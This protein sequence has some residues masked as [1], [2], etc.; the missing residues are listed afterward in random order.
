DGPAGAVDIRRCAGAEPVDQVPV[1]PGQMSS[2]LYTSGSTGVPKGVVLSHAARLTISAS[3]PVD[4]SGPGARCGVVSTGSSGGTEGVLCIPLVMGGTLVPYDV[5]ERGLGELPAWLRARR[6][7]SLRTVPTV[8]RQLAGALEPGERFDDL[9]SVALFGEQ[10]HWAEVPRLRRA[11]GVGAVIH[12]TYGSSEAGIVTSYAVGPD[13]RHGRGPV[14]VGRAVPGRSVVVDDDGEL[15]AIGDPARVPGS[16]WRRPELTV[17]RFGVDADGRRTC[18]TG[19]RGRLDGDGNLHLDGR[20]D[21]VVKIGGVR[22]DRAEVESVLADLAGVTGAAAITRT[23]RH[24]DLRLH[25]F[26]TVDDPAVAAR[27]LRSALER[28]LP[29]AMRPDTITLVDAL[30]RLPGGKVDRAALARIPTV[31][32]AERPTTVEAPTVGAPTV[33]P[34]LAAIWAEAVDRSPTGIGSDDDFFDL[35]GD[36]LRATRMFAEIDRQLGVGLPVATLLTAPTLRSLDGVVRAAR[37]GD[38][39][40]A[41]VVVIREPAADPRRPALIVLHDGLGQIMGA[42]QLARHLGPDQPIYA[43]APHELSGHPTPARTLEELAADY[44]HHLDDRLPPGPWVLF[45]QSFGG[46]IAFEIGRQ[47][48]EGGREVALVVLGDSVA[49]GRPSPWARRPSGAAGA[50]VARR[51]LETRD[52]PWPE[53]ARQAAVGAVRLTIGVLRR[54]ARHAR[55]RWSSARVRLV[56]ARGRPVPLD[57]REPLITERC[58]AMAAGYAPA[59]YPGEVVLVASSNGDPGS[60]AVWAERSGTFRRHDVSAAHH[61]MLREPGVATVAAILAEEIDRVTAAAAPPTGPRRSGEPVGAP[62]A[63]GVVPGLGGHGDASRRPA[64]DLAGHGDGRDQR[65]PAAPGDVDGHGA[66]LG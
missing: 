63:P 28:R 15:V 23:D 7:T 5:G 39:R 55:S 12:N 27:D 17:E 19:D 64:V 65:D 40:W 37:G 66:D 4:T 46:M 62:A 30:P 49:P 2:I 44:L 52:L 16:Y 25:A 8:L 24:G 32:P 50:I 54:Q 11:L 33:E 47:A 45:G 14:P 34:R 43:V 58:I 18:R 20:V 48:R 51:R 9:V 13:L 42:R 26:V 1:E 61:D 36:S 10:L 35:G 3:L 22:V 6:V 41:P 31:P 38:Q 59:D 56:V 57:L 21:D 60:A 53:R 29:R